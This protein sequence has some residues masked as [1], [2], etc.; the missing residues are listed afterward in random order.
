MHYSNCGWTMPKS[1]Q[2]QRI[3]NVCC[4][5]YIFRGNHAVEKELIKFNAVQQGQHR[6]RL[7]CNICS[8]LRGV[9]AGKSICACTLD[10]T[11]WPKW[12]TEPIKS[13]LSDAMWVIL[14]LSSCTNLDIIHTH[15]LLQLLLVLLRLSCERLPGILQQTVLL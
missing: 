15:H 11:A 13:V 6:A 9:M 1:I 12:V 5:V 10:H 7:N 3:V 8:V 4:S 14:N 2:A